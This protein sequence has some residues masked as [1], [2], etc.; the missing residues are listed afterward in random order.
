MR[1]R[2]RR[3]VSL[4][5]RIALA[6]VWCAAGWAKIQ[7]PQASVH[8]VR[9]YRVLPEALLTPV[10]YGLPA[11]ELAL[12][13]LLLLGLRCRLAAVLSAALL[14]AFLAGIVQAAIRGMSIDC[15]CFGGGGEVAASDT[16]YTKEILRDLGLICLSA[17]LIHRPASRYALDDLFD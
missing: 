12:A 15:G 11:L 8:A 10:G 17:R 3:S 1:K 6:V 5:A 14:V 16:R 4:V 7:D 13:A 2:Y 9:V